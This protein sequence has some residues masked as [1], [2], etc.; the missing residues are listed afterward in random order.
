V[1]SSAHSANGTDLGAR[2]ITHGP[3]TRRSLT[4]LYDAYADFVYRSLVSLGVPT[5]NAEDAMQDVFL[6]AH[7][8]LDAFQGPFFKAWLFR[9]AFSIARNIRR[10]V[11]RADKAN[12]ALDLDTLP[13]PRGDSPFDDAARAEKIRLLHQL[14][15]HLEDEKRQ[16]FILAEL[17]Q[18]PQVEIAAALG[19]HV[20]TVAYRLSAARERLQ[21]LLQRFHA[22]GERK[23]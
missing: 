2:P 8:K 23:S 12:V 14:L 9:L 21:Q 15:E 13:D 6:V 11:R 1:A 5:A 19:I 22:R 3:P 17:E 7:A 4:D 18:M 20:N 16:V 10:S